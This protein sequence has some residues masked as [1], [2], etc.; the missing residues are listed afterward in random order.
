MSGL[1]PT[2]RSPSSHAALSSLTSCEERKLLLV[3][4][5]K[6]LRLIQLETDESNFRF[7]THTQVEL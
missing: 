7:G 6:A 5:Q 3:F 4:G 2:L 1:I